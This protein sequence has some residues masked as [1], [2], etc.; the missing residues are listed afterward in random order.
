MSTCLPEQASV[1]L[2]EVEKDKNFMRSLANYSNL[3]IRISRLRIFRRNN[4]NGKSYFFVVKSDEIPGC[5]A[6]GSTV[7]EALVNFQK[8]A[9]VWLKWFDDSFA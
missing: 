9:E 7:S 2:L 8:T 6:H 3:T 1:I 4:H 5:A